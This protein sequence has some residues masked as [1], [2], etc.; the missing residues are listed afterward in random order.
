[1]APPRNAQKGPRNQRYY[2]IRGQ[3]FYS[4]TNITK[5]GL[6]EGYGLQ[7]WKRTSVANAAVAATQEGFLQKM[8]AASPKGAVEY[9]ADAP[10]SSSSK[11]RDIGTEVHEL[12]EALIVGKPAPDPSDDARPFIEQYRAFMDE[13]K[14]EVLMA[15]ATVF[16]PSHWWAGTLDAVMAFPGCPLPMVMDIKTGGVWPEVAL[17]LSAYAHAELIDTPG[18]DEPMIDVDQGRALVLDLSADRYR[19]REVR[20]DAE[21]YRTFLYV[22]ETF[23][24][25]QETSRSVLGGTFW[26]ASA[27]ASQ[28]TTLDVAAE[29]AATSGPEL[30]TEPVV[31]DTA[32]AERADDDE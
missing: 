28:Q 12:I 7:K 6:P 21:I 1:M 18:G 32:E 2:D 22:R 8:V 31:V 23:R 15:E 3:R 10:F 14:P 24:W 13:Y 29:P 19:L 17:Q 25:N 30:T 26:P 20:I 11:A 9:L 4:V 16:S 5:N 27:D